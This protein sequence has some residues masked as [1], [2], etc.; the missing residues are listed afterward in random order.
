M[1]LDLPQELISLIYS[2]DG[3]YKEIYNDILKEIKEKTPKFVDYYK[4]N[5]D[6]YVFDYKI[7]RKKISINITHYTSNGYYTS[8]KKAYNEAIIYLNENYL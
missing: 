8:Y 4:Y 1:F 6:I 5:N 3:T 2:Y 7:K